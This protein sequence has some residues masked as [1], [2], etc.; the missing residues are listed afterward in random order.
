MLTARQLLTFGATAWALIVIPGPSVLFVV[1]R[2]IALGR[3]AALATVVGNAAGQQVHVVA[4]ALGVGVLVARSVTVFDLMKVAGAVY[5][6]YLGAK[7]IRNAGALRLALTATT[8]PRSTRR[9]LGE[10]FVVGVT[11]PKTTIF[12]LAVLPQFVDRGHG[13]VPLQLLL[14]GVEFSMIALLSDSAYALAA[15]TVRRWFERRPARAGKVS[16]VSGLVMIALGVR[17]A[18]VGRAD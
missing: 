18:F 10:G 8:L 4:V 14:L 3:R 2:G 13:H 7:T 15:G 5:L 6:A 11:N 9:L 1:T 12:F 17:L 16:V